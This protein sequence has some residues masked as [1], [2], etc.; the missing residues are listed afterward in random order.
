MGSILLPALSRPLQVT[1]A[2]PP[3]H[4]P[5]SLSAL[6]TH[7]PV[8]CGT[9]YSAWAT[10]RPGTS[11]NSRRE[12]TCTTKGRRLLVHRSSAIAIGL[13]SISSDPLRLSGP[14]RIVPSRV[15]RS[16]PKRAT[17]TGRPSL[18][19]R[20]GADLSASNGPSCTEKSWWRRRWLAASGSATGSPSTWR[21]RRSAPGSRNGSST[22]AG[23]IR[24]ARIGRVESVV[25]PY[26]EANT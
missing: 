24:A 6:N 14:T 11:L 26:L 13:W 7:P 8:R 9:R 21:S 18:V 10:R 1:S 22:P 2:V 5:C 17:S 12:A 4:T 15:L 3:I 23:L 19:V 25:R 20:A 16:C